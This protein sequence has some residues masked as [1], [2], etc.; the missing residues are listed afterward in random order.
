[1]LERRTPGQAARREAQRRYRARVRRGVMAITIEVG[2]ELV[3]MLCR[4]RWLNGSAFEHSRAE[5]R[6]A[7]ERLLADVAAKL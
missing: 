2:P 4:L 6:S 1:V 5:I 3:D 7:L